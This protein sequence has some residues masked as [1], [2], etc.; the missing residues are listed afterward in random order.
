M[1]LSTSERLAVFPGTF[2]P[3]TNGHL[4]LIDRSL[5]IFDRVV[6]AVLV[7]PGKHPMFSLEDRVSM[8]RAATANRSRLE[9]EAFTGLLADYVRS[10]GATAVVRGVRS[11][12]EFTAESQMA[13]MN[14]HLNPAC[15]TVFLAA[16][17][18]C[19]H[20]S[21]SLVREILALG[22]SIDGLVPPAVADVASRRVP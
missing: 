3:L 9:V 11:G 2:D 14:R 6:A 1:T 10:R 21:S 15:E 16:S 13:R 20:I 7:N 4:D 19:A 22:G 12:S 18:A 17:G 8:I 5:A